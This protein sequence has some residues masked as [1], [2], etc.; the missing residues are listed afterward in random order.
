MIVYE[1]I[2]DCA[3]CEG[4]DGLDRDAQAGQW[5]TRTDHGPALWDAERDRGIPRFYM[6]G[7]SDGPMSRPAEEREAWRDHGC[8]G[9]Y[10]RSPFV[11]SI[12]RYVRRNG[13]SNRNYDTAPRHIVDLVHFY[14]SHLD[15][16][17]ALGSEMAHV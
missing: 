3:R 15:A 16:V 9:A 6:G 2:E 7:R 17:K 14:E 13:R 4:P 12:D 11:C 5:C 10:S 8:L 1:A